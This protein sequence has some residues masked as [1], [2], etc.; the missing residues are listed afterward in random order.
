MRKGFEGTKLK[1]STKFAIIISV[2]ICSYFEQFVSKELKII[3]FKAKKSSSF[4]S[5]RA[6]VSAQNAF[7]FT[8]YP[9][10]NPEAGLSGLNGLN[11]GRDFTGYPISRTVSLGIDASF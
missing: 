3:F 5:L 2:S 4:K 9:G 1:Y 8:Q 7:I 10:L 11:Q 6:F